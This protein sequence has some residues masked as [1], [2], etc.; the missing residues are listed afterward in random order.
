MIHKIRAFTLIE[1]MISIAILAILIGSLF[2]ITSDM[3]WIS[4]EAD[5]F[6]A[7][8]LMKLND[9]LVSEKSFYSL[10][11][12]VKVIPPDG[13]VSLENRYIIPKSVVVITSDSDTL[14]PDDYKLDSGNGLITFIPR[15]LTGKKVIVKYSYLIPDSGELCRVPEKSPFSVDLL[16]NPI[17]YV[18]MVE[19]IEGNRRSLVHNSFYKY[20]PGDD[21]ISFNKNM[22][23]HVVQVRYLGEKI[24]NVCSGRFINPETLNESSTPTEMKIIT[25]REVYGG[26]KNKIETVRM[27]RAENG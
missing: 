27:N 11:P 10:P 16:N 18:L 13:S 8:N 25:I 17:S 12:E 19:K 6:N 9:R 20:K 15:K 14:L 4:H 26:G 5:Y 7:V 3:R 2:I 1:I 21:S 24:K 22:A 23:G